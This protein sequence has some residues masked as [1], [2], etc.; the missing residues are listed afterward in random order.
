MRCASSFLP[1]EPRIVDV[2]VACHELNRLT[3]ARDRGRGQLYGAQ[4]QQSL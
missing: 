3:G 4:H 1:Q 2:A